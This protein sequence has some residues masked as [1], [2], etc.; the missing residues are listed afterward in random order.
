MRDRRFFRLWQEHG[1]HVTPVH[2]Y[3]PIPDTRALDERLWAKPSQLVGVDM[4]ESGQLE[5]M[6]TFVR[7]FEEEYATFPETQTDVP[8]QYYLRQDMFRGVDAE[9][10]YG[11]IRH[12]KPKRILEIG[13]GF[14]TYLAAQAVC[15]NQ[16]EDQASCRL[17]AMEPYP[18]AVLQKGFPGLAEL[19]TTRIQ[20]ISLAEFEALEPNDIL[21]I[22]SS[23]V[24]TVGS[25][26]QYEYL[27]V[28]PRVKKGVIIHAHDIWLPAEYPKDWVME[29]C[30]FWNEQ[31]LLQAFLSF[32][33]RFEVMWSSGYMHLNH[34]EKL[35][36]AFPSYLGDQ[37]IPVSFW[38]RRT[39]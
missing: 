26:V 17:I 23:H 2:H 9:I 30:R 18:N 24:A 32:N 6:T 8:H 5:L 25:D 34:P 38:M 14:S 15:R 27:E 16:Q 35:K 28:L 1:Y 31:Y 21:F 36:A 3:Q 20:D 29:K 10:L 19:R 7:Q 13:S 12:F 4:N 33:D 39:K 22:D 11:I 37:E